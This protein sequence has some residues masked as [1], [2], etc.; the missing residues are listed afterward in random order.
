MPEKKV[1][2]VIAPQNFR[3]EEYFDTKGVLSKRAEVVTAS[4]TTDQARGMLGGT[5]TPDITLEEA[6]VDEFDAVVF[7]GGV[8]AKVYFDSSRAKSIAREAFEKGK[9]VA[10]ICIAPTVLANAGVLKG[11]NATV[12]NDQG[13]I[14]NLQ[15]KGGKFLKQPVVADGKVITAE[16]PHAARAFGEE[17][18]KAMG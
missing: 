12:W 11:K 3:D 13:L 15:E 9:V 1:L 17:I 4:T 2:M 8:G 5:A 10:A 14:S 16:G 6:N 7:V 18:A